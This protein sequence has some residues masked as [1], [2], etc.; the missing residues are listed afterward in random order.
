M[1][2]VGGR[3]AGGSGSLELVVL[4]VDAYNVLHVTG[5][6]PPALA[7]IDLAGLAGLIGESRYGRARVV[8]VC[9]GAHR[10]VD[11]EILVGLEAVRGAG[12]GVRT[13]WAGPGRDADSLIEAYLAS[14]GRR[15]GVVVVSSD[16]RLR[17]AA[18]RERVKWVDSAKFLAQVAA[19]VERG[20]S[21]AGHGPARP[22]TPISGDAAEGWAERFGESYEAAVRMASGDER[23]RAEL[24]SSA[25]GKAVSTAG[26]PP[27]GGAGEGKKRDSGSG[28][29]G[30]DGVGGGGGREGKS[31][32][33]GDGGPALP[34]GEEVDPLILEALK[35]WPDALRLDDLDMERWLDR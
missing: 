20:G 25:A 30:G 27:S 6:L 5:V 13:V 9:D 11:E 28:E 2:L 12:H 7:G 33:D 23:R 31:G 22:R 10:G 15:S 21:S 19:D 18:K 4:L 34:R 35:E 24:L 8:L 3:V 14:P 26:R 1:G 16:R 29:G 32:R 17:R